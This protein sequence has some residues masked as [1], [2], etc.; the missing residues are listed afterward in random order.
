MAKQ[1]GVNWQLIKE[2]FSQ[3]TLAQINRFSS[4]T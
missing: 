4:K 1:P 2:R 3:E